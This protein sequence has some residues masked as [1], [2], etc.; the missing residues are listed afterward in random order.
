MTRPIGY[1]VHHQGRGHAER[2]LAIVSALPVT[3]PVV[4]FCAR[5][6]L[7]PALPPH[8]RL[9]IIPS[10]FEATGEENVALADIPTPRTLHC[11][12]LGWPGIRKAMGQ[13]VTWFAELTRP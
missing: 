7:F 11:A 9:V 12:P 6:D 1:F 13:I 5:A 10:L 8:I 4:I 3:R 2:C